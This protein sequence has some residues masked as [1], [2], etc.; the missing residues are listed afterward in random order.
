MH[1]RL[2]GVA[3][4]C[5]LT[6]VCR[7]P[8]AGQGGARVVTVGTGLWG[9]WPTPPDPS[10]FSSA[11]FG[12]LRLGQQRVPAGRRLASQAREGLPGVRE[13]GHC[14]P[15]SLSVRVPRDAT[16]VWRALATGASAPLPELCPTGIRRPPGVPPASPGVPPA[17]VCPRCAPRLPPHRTA[18][19]GSV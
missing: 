15:R 10:T 19:A 14:L 3:P 16:P 9:A 7:S 2:V 8:G 18:P 4:W 17:S 13:R 5:E 1:R 6:T 11:A 12:S